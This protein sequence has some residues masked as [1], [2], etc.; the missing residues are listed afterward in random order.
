MNDGRPPSVATPVE[1]PEPSTTA[2]IQNASRRSLGRP[3]VPLLVGLGLLA[4]AGLLWYSEHEQTRALQHRREALASLELVALHRRALAD[5]ARTVEASRERDALESRLRALVGDLDV[6]LRSVGA[7]AGA[8]GLREANEAL[9]ETERLALRLL[10]TGQPVEA[11]GL[12]RDASHGA[13]ARRFSEGLETARQALEAE[14]EAA[15]RRARARSRLAGASAAAGAVLVAFG[16]WSSVGVVRV[17]RK[18]EEDLGGKA[19]QLARFGS[20]LRQQHRLSTT[21]YASTDDLLRDYLRAGC[22]SFGADIGMLV[23]RTDAGPE[24]RGL[25]SRAAPPPDM[26][27]PE[28]AELLSAPVEVAGSS[29]FWGGGAFAGEAPER[30][31]LRGNGV[32]SYLGTPVVVDGAPYGVLAFA[33]RSDRMAGGTV[34]D[35]EVMEVLAQGLARGL[36]DERRQSERERARQALVEAREAAQEASRL[37]S[38]F[39][40][41]TNHELRTPLNAII[42]T[43]QLLL[44]TPLDAEQRDYVEMAATSGEALLGIINGLLDLSKIE[45]GKLDLEAVDFHLSEVVDDVV[46]MSAHR[47]REKGIE[48]VFACAPGSPSVLRGDPGRLRQ[49]LNNLL[50]NA[51][52]FTDRGEVVVRVGIPPEPRTGMRFEVSDTGIGIA[53]ESQARLFQP[54][55][56]A[57]EAA[58][59]R[60]GGTGLG[61]AICKH[62][63]QAMGGVIGL[64][65]EVG[66]GS[67]FWFE[68][69][70]PI[71]GT[72]DAS[73]LR[74]RRILVAVEGASQRA[75][76]DG[77]LV[78]WGAVSEAVADGASALALLRAAPG[79]FEAVVV[80]T[81]DRI[82]GV[83]PATGSAQPTGDVRVVRVEQSAHEG[84]PARGA[85]AAR[86]PKP[87]RISR[88]RAALEA[89][90]PA[91]SAGPASSPRDAVPRSARPS[92][93]GQPKKANV[94]VV[95]DDPAGRRVAFALLARLGCAVDAV[96]SGAAALSSLAGRD[97]DLVLMDCRMPGLDGFETTAAI[98][99]RE[100]AAGRTPIVALTAG[101]T[102]DERRRCLSAGM[103]DCLAKPVR[104]A[105]L[106]R[107][108]DRWL[109]TPSP[110][111]A[112]DGDALPRGGGDEP[113]DVLTGLREFVGDDDPGA[114]AELLD[115]MLRDTPVRLRNLCL[116]AERGDSQAVSFAAH[117]LKTRFGILGSPAMV[118]LCDDLER[119][120]GELGRD[121]TPM[122]RD[123]DRRYGRM[124]PLLEAARLRLP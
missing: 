33:S 80:D 2:L 65:S 119:I 84:A 99:R 89:I 21:R 44:D 74:D 63:V 59:R 94:L 81:R 25:E 50:A 120:A 40:A 46:G 76:L 66:R 124:Q 32:R 1:E 88:L 57:Q 34:R 4:V 29:V 19:S 55:T 69:P 51:V 102:E 104:V 93:T 116:A 45:S 27:A 97:Y 91:P 5:G 10:A 85:V 41:H 71:G 70:T 58:T 64:T 73:V 14:F 83:E 49:V 11:D 68:L 43:T 12:L 108:L 62:L 3:L 6:R 115:L 23:Q 60:Q 95:D 110:S 106:E 48:I 38:E 61:L 53:P 77:W 39:L 35:I 103:D 36:A 123:L 24:A 107:A 52:R 121:T 100:G 114:L 82:D 90:L 17:L 7:A 105:D 37:K 87:V 111:R 96:S 56:Q 47:A 79:R 13:R 75:A 20:L 22:E 9:S 118:M 31:A 30:A 113:G 117:A 112:E 109:P 78:Q 86:V 54:F 42:G 122:A 101:A 16:A 8:A 67:T 28:S 92:A 72:A 26:L 15:D 18:A 98:R